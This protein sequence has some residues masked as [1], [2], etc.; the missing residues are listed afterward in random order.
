MTKGLSGKVAVV[1]GGASGLGEAIVERFVADGARVVV[2]DLNDADGKRVAARHGSAALFCHTDVAD[3]EQVAALVA[4]AVDHFGALDVMV[5][6]AAIS[7]TRRHDFLEDD[8]ADFDRVMSVNLFGVMVGTRD[9]ARHMARHGGGSIINMSSIGGIEASPGVMP[10]VASK[11]AVI[12]FSKAAALALADHEIRV[13]CIAAGEGIVLDLSPANWDESVFPE[14]ARLDLER[15][16]GNHVAFGFGPHQCVGHLVG[17]TAA[18]IASCRPR[19][20]SWSASSLSATPEWP[21]TQ[22]HSTRWRAQAF[23]RRCHR[24][25]F[26]TGCFAAVRQPLRSQP[27]THLVMPLRT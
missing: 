5:N 26:F 19:V 24:S 3:R 15:P 25:T 22:N 13:N 4:T 11:A 14:P 10:Y 6:N 21:F 2:A 9:A 17:T 8:L 1:T 27:S 12:H 18:A 20:A 7:G 23:W 16:A